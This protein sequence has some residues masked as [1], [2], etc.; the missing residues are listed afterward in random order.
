MIPSPTWIKIP[1][2]LAQRHPAFGLRRGSLAAFSCLLA[3]GLL[4][5]L[6]GVVQDWPDAPDILEASLWDT[7]AVPFIVGVMVIEFGFVGAWFFRWR[8]C[9]VAFGVLT[10][11]EAFAAL[12]PVGMVASAVSNGEL[13]AAIAW[14]IALSPLILF[15]LGTGVRLAFL[16]FMA[17]ST[18]FRV[19]FENRVR[20]DDPIMREMGLSSG[21]AV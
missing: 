1:T 21:Q 15:I 17:R 16:L 6:A 7:L 14:P 2:A 3:A 20:P 13:T 5:S 8:G 9:R 4:R 11:M 12:A 10:V 19:T 18:A